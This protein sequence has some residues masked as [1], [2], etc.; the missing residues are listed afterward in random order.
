MVARDG[1]DVDKPRGNEYE[2]V[3]EILDYGWHNTSS[4]GFNMR[5]EQAFAEKFGGNYAITHNSG[6]GT[7]HSCLIAAG[8]G[9]GDEVII[10]PL[11]AAATAL[12]V[13]HQN[14]VPVFADLDPDTFNIDPEA[15]RELITPPHSGNYPGGLVRPLRRYESHNGNS[16]G[17]RSGSD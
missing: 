10:P 11:T 7:M 9:P 5:L 13:I 17:T 6:T 8:I 15:I 16:R 4:P 12:V 1:A 3:T 2:Y 14:A